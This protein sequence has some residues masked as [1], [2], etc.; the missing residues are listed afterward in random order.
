MI[1]KKHNKKRNYTVLD[2]ELINDKC[3]SFR[4]LGVLTYLLSKPETWE[5]KIP[6]LTSRPRKE[7]VNAIKTALKELRNAKYVILRRGE[8]KDSNGERKLGSWYDVYEEPQP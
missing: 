2:N 5:A 7:G 4:A 6:D 8:F 3:L 1:F